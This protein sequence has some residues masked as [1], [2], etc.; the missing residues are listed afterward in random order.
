M[1]AGCQVIVL[2][3]PY[4]VHHGSSLSGASCPTSWTIFRSLSLL[5]IQI[6]TRV[7]FL[8]RGKP[9]VGTVT[10]IE[11]I[12][13]C[14]FVSYGVGCPFVSYS[15][16]TSITCPCPKGLNY[17]VLHLD[18]ESAK[19]IKLPCVNLLLYCLLLVYPSDQCVASLA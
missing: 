11:T 12:E 14:P 17:V 4:F 16:L 5:G 3:S 9:Y 8:E 2:F 6:G 15:I 7:F 18:E 19:P 1:G 10:E 13:V